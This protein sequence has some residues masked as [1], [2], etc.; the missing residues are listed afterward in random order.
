[1][2]DMA[3]ESLDKDPHLYTICSRNFKTC[4]IDDSY[5]VIVAKALQEHV[6]KSQ[7]RGFW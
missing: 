6:R 7:N 1:M 4:F 5:D 3:S 2:V